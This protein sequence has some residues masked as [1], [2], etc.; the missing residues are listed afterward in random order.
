MDEQLH[1]IKHRCNNIFILIHDDVIKWKHFPRYWPFVWR[2]HR[3]PVNSPH[4]GQ[5][6]GALMFSL[7]CD[8]KNGWVSNN[9]AGDLRRH[10]A[11][12]DV[13]VI[14]VRHQSDL[15]TTD[16]LLYQSVLCMYRHYRG[17][18]RNQQLL[19]DSQYW[20]WCHDM[21]IF[22]A[23]LALCERNPPVTRWFPSQRPA[24]RSFD[25]FFDVRLYMR[26]NKH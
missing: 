7:I 3:S 10:Q 26:L 6:P 16:V 25:V 18:F 24:T 20:W 8:R 4:K 21:E 15:A 12:C 22:S 9:E 23:L 2:I 13:I 19:D 1:P 11:H 14:S 5:W 17:C